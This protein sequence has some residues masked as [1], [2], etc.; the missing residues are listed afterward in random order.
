MT[1]VVEG[2]ASYVLFNIISGRGRE[3][4]GHGSLSLCIPLGARGVGVGSTYVDL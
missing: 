2:T 1:R 3:R 4:G